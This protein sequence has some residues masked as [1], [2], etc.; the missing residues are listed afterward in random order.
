MNCKPPR[1]LFWGNSL[2]K[3]G[4]TTALLFLNVFA[5]KSQ[6]YFNRLYDIALAASS[7]LSVNDGYFLSTQIQ[8]G[9]SVGIFS[10]QT[11]SMGNV[12]GGDSSLI[13]GYGLF[14]QE[15]GSSRLINGNIFFLGNPQ[16][17]NFD[18]KGALFKYSGGESKEVDCYKYQD[19]ISVFFNSMVVTSKGHLTITGLAQKYTGG[20]NVYQS[21]LLVTQLDTSGNKLWEHS[22]PA[23]SGLWAL[24]GNT[25]IGTKNGGFAVGGLALNFQIL[26]SFTSYVL[27]ADNLGNKVS[28]RYLKFGN[29]GNYSMD[30][31]E[32]PNGNFLVAYGTTYKS[33]PASEDQSRKLIVLEL[34]K[35]DLSTIWEKDY[36]EGYLN[37]LTVSRLIPQNDSTYLIAGT[38]HPDYYFYEGDYALRKGFIFAINSQGDSLWYR[39]FNNQTDSSE[40][41]YL[42]DIA[43]TPDGGI[44]GAGRLFT[45]NSPFTGGFANHVWLFKT[46]SIGCLYPGC[47]TVY[48]KPEPKKI[49]TFSIYPNPWPSGTDLIIRV[50]EAVSGL[51][52]L[53]NSMGQLVRQQN[54]DFENGTARFSPSLGLVPGCYF[55][56]LQDQNGRVFKEKLI[57][58]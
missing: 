7:V 53:Y 42:N 25:I 21:Q 12:I 39:D 40:E 20:P 26:P 6:V 51:A 2:N 58:N 49:F 19:S 18:F 38:Y 47:D 22:Y 32:L 35:N 11:D 16:K 50:P 30:L 17:T 36:L 37:S 28:E 27:L 3:A 13:Q 57:L 23:K 33:F 54:L 14:P 24:E 46:D 9:N 56:H 10:M 5:L 48:I 4:L 52:S 29:Y 44:V 43:I 8:P 1:W 31:T 15:P 34:D 45:P 41:S 55:L